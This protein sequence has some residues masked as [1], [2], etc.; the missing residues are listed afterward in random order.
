MNSLT[1]TDDQ[2]SMSYCS[3]FLRQ[4]PESV[5]AVLVRDPPTSIT[6]L[7]KAADDILSAQSPASGIAAV[8]A[9]KMGRRAH[10]SSGKTG[11][12]C[13]SHA[14]FG[15]KA[16]KCGDTSSAATCDMAHL[17]EL[18]KCLRRPLAVKAVGNHHQD[19]R[20]T[21]S[22]WD[23]KTGRHYLN[24]TDAD[25]SVFPS[26]PTDRQH[27]STTQPLAAANDS[28]LATWG[29]R[30]IIV[31]L[32]S[33]SSTQSIHIA[34]VRQPI[35][36]ADFLVSNNLVVDLRGRR[37]IDLFSYSIIPTTAALGSHRLGIHR[38]RTYDNDLASILNE[39]PELLVPRFHASDENLHGVEH[40]LTTTGPPVFGRARRLHDEQLAVAKAEFKKME[41]LGIIRRSYLPWS[42]PLYITPKPGGGWRPCG[43]FRRLNAATIDDRYPIPHIGDFNGNLQG[44]TIFSKIDLARGYHQI[45]MAESDN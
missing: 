30:N 36:G 44:K 10:P 5:C 31:H 28:R 9:G 25:E 3:L 33:R 40:H 8:S 26:S 13:F 4:L 41:D 24:D 16:C 32:G 38:V 6:D 17:T 14:K 11:T 29:Q 35:L 21:M 27:C 19:G 42:S 34:D 18:G 1:T 20:N 37:L 12:C 15:K 23:C 43:D 22:I 2:K 45:P 39:F 7:A